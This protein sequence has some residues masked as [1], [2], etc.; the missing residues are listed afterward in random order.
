MALSQMSKNDLSFVVDLMEGKKL[1]RC[2][3][4][5]KNLE[6][7]RHVSSTCQKWEDSFTCYPCWRMKESQAWRHPKIGCL[8]CKSKDKTY[9]T[10]WA[11][12]LC[13]DC[14]SELFCKKHKTEKFQ[15]FSS[16][17][18]TCKGCLKMRAPYWRGMWRHAYTPENPN[19]CWRCGKLVFERWRRDWAEQC[20]PEL[21]KD[22]LRICECELT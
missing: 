10:D 2:R 11:Y 14:E 15:L 16:G 17:N 1:R 18:K 12:A 3:H 21:Y 7:V 8:R 5:N 19:Y 22:G 20:W 9:V 13:I 6:G 4:C